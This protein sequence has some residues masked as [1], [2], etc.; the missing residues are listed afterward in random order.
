MVPNT[1]TSANKQV[2]EN[3]TLLGIE[4]TVTQNLCP[5]IITFARVVATTSYTPK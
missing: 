2:G 5:G 1:S 4:E 3:F